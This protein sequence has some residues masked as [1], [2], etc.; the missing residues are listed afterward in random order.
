VVV[1]LHAI[2]ALHSVVRAS[3]FIVIDANTGFILAAR[4]ENRKVPVASL[5]KIATAAVVID[6]L[7]LSKN[8][9][10]QLVTVSPEAAAT[11]GVNPVGLRPGDRLS[12]RD[13]LYCALLQSDNIAAA[14]LAHHVGSVLLRTGAQGGSPINAFVFQMNQLAIKLRMRRTRFINPTGLDSGNQAGLSSA[15]DM[16]RLTQYAIKN[17]AFR[18]YV[19]QKERRIQIFRPEG[20]SGYMLR[21]TNQLLGSMGIDGVKTGRTARAGDCLVLS[22]AREPESR[23]EGERFIITPR[24]LIVVLL[25]SRDRF[26]EG[27]ALLRRGWSSYD[28]WA[29]QGRP[30]DPKLTL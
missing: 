9:A 19:S 25:N 1:V 29:A 27:A 28:A 2:L 17:S 22:A 26:A 13:L 15:G 11:G 12:I 6:W 23:K 5:T 24:R 7:D 10:S 21:N 16:A 3:S 14:A 30:V 4:D 20:T 18:F 8:D